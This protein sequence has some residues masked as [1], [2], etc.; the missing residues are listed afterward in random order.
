MIADQHGTVFCDLGN[1]YLAS[2]ALDRKTCGAVN[3]ERS[4]TGG[5]LRLTGLDQPETKLVDQ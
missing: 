1:T 5:C 3:A 2:T 4:H